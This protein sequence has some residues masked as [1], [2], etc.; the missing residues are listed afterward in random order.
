MTMTTMDV[1]AAADLMR[2]AALFHGLGERTRLAIVAQ[3]AA[4]ERR[5]VDLT[6]VLGLAQGTVSGHLACLRD[7]G[8]IVG[9]PEGR[10]MF[11]SL[12]HPELMDLL[13]SAERLLALTGEA[14][15]LCP[16]YGC[17]DDLPSAASTGVRARAA[18]EGAT[19]E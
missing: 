10:Q 14:V 1:P 18:E 15:A 5:V 17:S 6:T 9:R 7:C 2:G 16:N 12:A 8:L 19:N 4:G 11:Y 13:A 3:L